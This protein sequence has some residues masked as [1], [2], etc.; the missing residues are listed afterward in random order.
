[1]STYSDMNP[2]DRRT[3]NRSRSF[4]H[5]K[6]LFNDNKSVYD[7]VLRNVTAYGATLEVAKPDLLPEEF[8]LL[9]VHENFTVP[10]AVKWRRG[11][12]LGVSF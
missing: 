10:C 9:I 12:S 7:A 2:H 8:R 3:R 5:A 4:K 11:D 1:M 6:I